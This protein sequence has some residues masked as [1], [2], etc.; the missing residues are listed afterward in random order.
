M[1]Y[2]SSI[3]QRNLLQTLFQNTTIV[4]D[5]T[6]PNSPATVAYVN[7]E[8]DPLI[9]EVQ[10]LQQ[11]TTSLQNS[12]TALQIQANTIEAEVPRIVGSIMMVMSPSAP[13]YSLLCD[14]SLYSTVAYPNLFAVIGYN[15][16]GSGSQFAVPNFQSYFP[17][18]GNSN[19][20]G[21]A[22]SNIMT[23]NGQI[24]AINTFSVSGAPW[25][26]LGPTQPTFPI[27][28]RA[29]PHNHN[30]VDNG[31]SHFISDTG[32]TN[33]PVLGTTPFL[34]TSSTSGRVDTTNSKTGI[35]IAT[36]G[37]NIQQRDPTSNIQGINVTPPYLATNFFITY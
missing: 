11:L 27:I 20:N 23:G 19:V 22:V 29:P 28:N 10:N 32:F 12:I 24:G 21:V 26:A 30:I 35:T 36:S 9:T 7:S 1:S 2:R 33:L 31:H 18:G 13:P 37:T 17:V 4:S 5:S 16:G 8:V 34:N 14:G 25:T 15:Y 3:N 6:N